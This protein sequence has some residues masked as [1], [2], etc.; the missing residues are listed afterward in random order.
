VA[1][2][3]EQ[4]TRRCAVYRVV[5][6]Q[7]GRDYVGIS[8]DHKQRWYKHRWDAAN[9]CAFHFARAL[10][11]YGPESFDWLVIGWANSFEIAAEHEQLLRFFGMGYYNM[12]EGGEGAVGHVTTQETRDKLSAIN[13]G[14]KHTEE[15]KAKI[16]KMA[17]KRRPPGE[18]AGYNRA[19]KD[20]CK[21]R[22]VFYGPKLPQELRAQR[23]TEKR[24]RPKTL[25]AEHRANISKALTGKI[26][27][28][29]VKDKCRASSLARFVKK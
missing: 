2:T 18:P 6:R 12:T 28:Q 17:E 14:R 21:R 24:G 11:K 29:A 10:N 4:S 27:P 26:K 13:K 25:S 16:R 5:H 1:E 20:G 7:S 3:R 23:K 15:T 8:V 19:G 22:Q 9:G